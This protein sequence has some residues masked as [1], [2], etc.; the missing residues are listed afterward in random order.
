[1]SGVTFK[2]IF[3]GKQCEFGE[4]INVDHGLIGRLE[5]Y[6]IIKKTQGNTILVTVVTVCKFRWN[7]KEKSYS[8]AWR[9]NEI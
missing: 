3:E 1:M 6:R 5:D 8:S 4:K 9:A 2:S 7:Y